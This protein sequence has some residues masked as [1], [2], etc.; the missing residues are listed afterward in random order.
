MASGGRVEARNVNV[1]SGGTLTGD[2]GTIAAD[3]ILDGGTIAPGASPGT[4]TIDGDL[5][6]FDGILAFEIAGSA[7][8]LFDRLVVTGDLIADALSIEVTFLDGFLPMAG[9]AF[10]LLDVAGTAEVFALGGATFSFFGVPE[11]AATGAFDGGVF[12]VA[13]APGDGGGG[14][15]VA[16]IP[17]PAGLPMLLLALGGTAALRRRG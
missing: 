16:P 17:V 12:S 15:P 14:D 3:V 10:D 6:V 11:G 7:P 13:A 1:R 9:D 2:G 5:E 4:M 8:G